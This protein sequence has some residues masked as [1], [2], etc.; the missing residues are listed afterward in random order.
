MAIVYRHRRLDTNEVFYVGIGKHRYRARSTH[1]RNKWWRSITNK[2]NYN[3]EIVWEGDCYEE[4]KELECLLIKEYGRKD[5]KCGTLVNLTDGGEGSKGF[6]HSEY[7]KGLISKNNARVGYWK[8]KKREVGC[9]QPKPIIQIDL[10]GVIIKEWNSIDE[11]SKSL[12]IKDSNI[13]LVC[14][15]KR[16]TAGGFTW[17]YVNEEHKKSYI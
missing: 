10:S 4:A 2:V 6:K 14:K 9:R 1:N 7:S 16:N 15:G 8:G 17:K 13:S 12:S 3:V 11:A 5:M